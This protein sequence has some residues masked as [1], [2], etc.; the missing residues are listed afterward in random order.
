MPGK[1]QDVLQKVDIPDLSESLDEMNFVIEMVEKAS[2]ATATQQ[3]VQTQ[4]QITLGEVQLALAEAKERVKGMSKFY[5]QVWKERGL[6]FLKL[7]EAA[8]DKL[9]SVKIYKKGRNTD[10]IYSK[11]I[12][13]K[14]W[15]TKSG[16]RVKVWSQ[17][18]KNA[19]TTEELQK[20]NAVKMNMP[21]N[22]KVDEVYKRKLVEFAGL[23][24]DEINEIME[25]EEQKREAMLNQPL[26]GGMPGQP[27]LPMP[28]QQAQP[29]MPNQPI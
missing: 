1:P 19:E 23:T 20:I 24:P 2:G 25:Y 17:D 12:A 28:Q 18:E 8:S 10:E 27:G 5:T 7:I 9:D 4:R 13:P 3:G 15:M 21:D 11:E 29:A 14:D 26:L 16:Y 22:P 6:M